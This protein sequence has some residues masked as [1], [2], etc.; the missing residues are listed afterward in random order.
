MRSNS[1]MSVHW[2]IT[3]LAGL[4]LVVTS[5]FL[6][7]FSV[8]NALSSQE[9][10]LKH[11]TAS[12]IEQSQQILIG[13]AQNNAAELKTYLDEATYRAEMLAENALFLKAN[14]EDNFTPSEDLRTALTEM[15][16]RSVERFPSVLGVYLV[17]DPD[18]LDGEDSNYHGADYVG[19]ND[20]GQFATYSFV[21][22]NDDIEKVTLSKG[23]L[24]KAGNASRF[25]CVRQSLAPCVASPQTTIVQGVETLLAGISVPL[26]VDDE[27]VGVLGLEL[28]LNALQQAVLKSDAQIFSGTGKVALL[29]HDS[30]RIASDDPEAAIGQ[31]FQSDTVSNNQISDYLAN[32]SV[33]TDWSAD[34]EWLAVYSPVAVADQY[35]GVLIEVPRSSAVANAMTLDNV[36]SER[37]QGAILT[38]L[39]VGVVM[40]VLGLVVIAGSSF[41]LVQPIREVVARLDDIASGEG[42][43]TQRLQV[44]SK[45]EIGQLATGFN[46]FLEK[47]QVTI[48]EV[49]ATSHDIG[50]TSAQAGQAASETHRSSDAQFKEVDLVATA[51]EELTQ[52]AALVVQNAAIAV[53]SATEA[54]Q[55]AK[56]GQ[57]VISSSA[58]EMNDL[59]ERMSRAV[60]V[61][62]E[63]ANN[64][65]NITETLTVIEGISEQTN[66]LAL[67]AAIEAARAGEQGRGFAVV[68]DE[69]RNLA[70]RTQE[71]VKEIHQVISQVQQGTKDV[72]DAIS[73][74]SQM[75]EKT[76]HQVE[77]AVEQIESIF[78][79]ISAINDMNS[80][81]MK[82]AEE[83]QSVSTE[84]N[85]NVANIRDLSEQILNQ[86]E[87]SERVSQEMSAISTRQQDL[88]GQF[89][90]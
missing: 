78:T 47:L 48:K 57:E 24:N 68:A 58:Q 3:L 87:S 73:E 74:G 62:Q 76:S 89:K 65:Q 17:F 83:Q 36:I 82:A 23:E 90:V 45:D 12:V 8:F 59:V 37:N 55:A 22:Q 4:S 40:I 11:S 29:S 84:L 30:Q 9:E 60:P 5:C 56:Q 34:G 27:V 6:V 1:G 38:E 32:H 81:I 51:S 49:V 61:V 64:N 10:T 66:L 77:A 16:Y 41:K 2:K 21:G 53:D 33:K 14:A 63:L 20:V 44:N 79:A 54:N 42:D 70:S 28:S 67:N 18:A 85:Q 19:S 31:P 46:R 26:L 50:G 15:V 7:G 35:W 86:A 43:L 88:V 71:S 13:T 72:V 52:T 69:V 25:T 75:A 80:Q 39:T